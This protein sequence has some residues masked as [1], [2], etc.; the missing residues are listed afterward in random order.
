MLPNSFYKAIAI[1]ILKADKDNKKENYRPD[2][3]SVS[4]MN[5]DIKKN[6]NRYLQKLN[7]RTLQ[8]IV[9]HDQV[10][11]ISEIQ[12]WFNIN[13]SISLIQHIE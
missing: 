6:P 8:K 11:F 5:K 10:G 7:S 12:E 1:L 4:L 2:Y 13:K 9:C 3:R